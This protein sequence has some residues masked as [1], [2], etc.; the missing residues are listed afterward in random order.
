MNLLSLLGEFP[1]QGEI[2]HTPWE[3]WDERVERT[4]E[5]IQGIRDVTR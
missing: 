2:A 1:K 5:T 3:Q 4:Y